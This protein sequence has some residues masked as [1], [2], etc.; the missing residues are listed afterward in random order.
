MDHDG[1]WKEALDRYLEPFLRLCFPRVHAG[2][3]WSR[4]H[5]PLD[6]ELRQFLGDTQTRKRQVDRLYRVTAHDGTEEH[7]F[8]H[9]EVQSQPDRRLPQRMYWYYR[10]LTD[11]GQRRVVSLAVLADASPGFRPGPYEE[12]NLGCRVR[13]EY[14]TCKL[15]DFN[16]T[17]LAADDSPAAIV[18]LAQRAAQRRVQ[19][20]GERKTLKWDLT[21]RLYERGYCQ[22]EVVELF[23]LIDWLLKLPEDLEVE[24]QAEL[25]EYEGQK[26]MP[27][28]TSIERMSLRRGRQEGLEQG[29]ARGRQKGR[30]EG[31]QE[32]K[33]L[34]AREAVR[35][36]LETRFGRLPAPLLK[37]L[38][39]LNDLA[40]LKQLLRRASAVGS[41]E[42]FATRV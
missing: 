15:L 21:R 42:E 32:G 38:S 27:Y 14:P 9:V 20:P 28:I 23:R 36:V 30:Q 19:S 8:L 31:R 39:D 16:D 4:A 37:H 2:I 1:F 12:A 5:V 13:F 35:L 40:R 24:F 25:T 17:Q 18:I 11:R 33:L 29:L 34:A 7:L 26:R 3:D 22:E 10:R 6:Q 41:L